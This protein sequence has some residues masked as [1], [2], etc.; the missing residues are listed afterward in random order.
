[1]ILVIGGLA[2]TV[3]WVAATHLPARTSQYISRSFQEAT[4]QAGFTLQNIMV[5]GRVNADPEVLRALIGMQRGDAVFGMN[6]AAMRERLEQ[7]PWIAHAEVERRLPDT[8]YI[9]LTERVP[10]ALWQTK[11]K[12]RLI[13]KDGVTLTDEKLDRFSDLMLVVGED[14]PSRMGELSGLLQ[15]EPEIARNVEAA[16]LVGSRRWDLRMKNG[17][18]VRL[19]ESDAGLA[20]SRL[21]RA[22]KEDHILERELT[23]IDL[24]DADRIIVATKPGAAQDYK[25]SPD[26]SNI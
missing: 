1:V 15:G 20:L 13:A 21:A 5:E 3:G 16:T 4:A 25:P 17:V 12:L 18:T 23:M 26:E 2:C 10:E 14:A 22:Q 7:M 11:G 24:R 6:P 19:P 9:R 8:V